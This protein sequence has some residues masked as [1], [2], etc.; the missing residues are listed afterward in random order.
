M[1]P[2]LVGLAKRGRSDGDGLD[3]AIRVVDDDLPLTFAEIGEASKGAQ[4]LLT[5]MASIPDL[6]SAAVGLINEA[7]PS[8]VKRV[9]IS[10]QVDLIA[11]PPG[12]SQGTLGL[13]QGVGALH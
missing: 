2:R 5:Q 7:L 12:G 13:R 1:I 9:F 4:T 6:R 8:A 11:V 10:S 3:D